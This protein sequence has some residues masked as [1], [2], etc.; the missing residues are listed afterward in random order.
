[1][2]R[3]DKIQVIQVVFEAVMHMLYI[4]AGGLVGVYI[5]PA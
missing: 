2:Q 1:M 5:T 3:G 4:M